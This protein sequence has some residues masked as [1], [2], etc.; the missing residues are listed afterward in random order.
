MRSPQT[1]F[2]TASRTEGNTIQSTK[3]MSNT[4]RQYLNATRLGSSLCFTVTW[5]VSVCPDQHRFYLHHQLCP[6]AHFTNEFLLVIQTSSEIV[7]IPFLF[8]RSLSFA[9]VNRVQLQWHVQN[10]GAIAVL[11]FR[12]EQHSISIK[13]KSSS[14]EKKS[15]LKWAPGLHHMWTCGWTTQYYVVVVGTPSW[16]I[17]AVQV[18]PPM[19]YDSNT[20]EKPGCWVQYTMYTDT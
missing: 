4:N 2:G 17:W 5:Y 11:E 20:R 6:G 3:A 7:T 15:Y 9:H 18:S 13:F 12:L 1:I 16:S 19:S 10:Y 8:I 14:E